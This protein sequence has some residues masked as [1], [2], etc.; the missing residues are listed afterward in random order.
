MELFAI[1][2]TG[3]KSASYLL[4]SERPY[5][6]TTKLKKM[7]VILPNECYT[8]SLECVY[9]LRHRTEVLV[10][11]SGSGHRNVASW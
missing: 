7:Q 3:F 10:S 6:L 4:C 11:H 1:L 9:A 8:A 2:F 5:V